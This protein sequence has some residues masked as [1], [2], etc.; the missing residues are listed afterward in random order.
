M[1]LF[2]AVVSKNYILEWLRKLENIFSKKKIANIHD[3][4]LIKHA[5]DL[6]SGKQS[7]YHP[8]YNLSKTELKILREY[9]ESSLKKSWI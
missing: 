6:K 1:A 8:I 7:P 3:A 9:I 5:I 4:A 2:A